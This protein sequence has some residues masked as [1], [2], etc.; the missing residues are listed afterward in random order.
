MTKHTS[1]LKEIAV[2]ECENAEIF[3]ARLLRRSLDRHIQIFLNV[4][5]LSDTYHTS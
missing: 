4:N 2:L 3:Q 5:V 1:L